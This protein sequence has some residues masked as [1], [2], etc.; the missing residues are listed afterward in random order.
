MR[1]ESTVRVV[2][3]GGGVAGAATAWALARSG[4]AE[5]T[6]L[7]Q[8]PQLGAHSTGR[9]AG[10][11]RTLT[12]DPAGTAL[13]LETAAFL[14]DPPPGF[15]EVPLLDPVGLVLVPAPGSEERV[16]S[17]RA[18]KP[19]GSVEG[20]DR[21]SLRALLPHYRGTARGAV[22]AR[23]EGVID[24]SALLDG[25]VRAAREAGATFKTSSRVRE[26]P[27]ATSSQV[28]RVRLDGGEELEA[29]AVV[30]AAGGWAGE[31]ARRAGSPLEFEPRRR[32]LLVTGADPRTD[33]RWPVLW[34]E[35]DGFYARPES[36]GL[37]LCAC[38]E[39]RV[40]PGEPEARPAVRERIAE[41]ARRCL[42]G[43]DEAPAA[44]FWAGLRTFA[45]DDGFAVGPDPEVP[46]L[47]WSAGLGGHGMSASIG[48]GQLAA[49]RLLETPH[50][51]EIAR[52]L[53]PRRLAALDRA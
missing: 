43:F 25:L 5:V 17:W 36:G 34:S 24:T 23:D 31:L 1:R 37:L 46:G 52:A 41:V 11:L 53:D 42:V 38:D 20:L 3:V 4:R 29:D 49:A 40:E 51:A 22:L 6:V 8:E 44:H 14:A 50:D 10:I 26:L 19:A 48:V 7:E 12:E 15:S 18:L 35:P 16:A 32:H 27:R 9:N 30:I 39:D 33:R 2:I 21:D 47:W 28:P 13:A 45:A